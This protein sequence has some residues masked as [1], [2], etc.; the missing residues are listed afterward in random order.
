MGFILHFPIPFEQIKIGGDSVV[1]F[2]RVTR[3]GRFLCRNTCISSQKVMSRFFAPVEDTLTPT[4]DTQKP[5]EG[6]QASVD[7][8]IGLHQC[9]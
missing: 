9:F 7:Q 2:E 4:D 5:V 1:Y 8:D 3:S 6:T